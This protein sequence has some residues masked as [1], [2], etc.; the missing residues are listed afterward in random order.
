MSAGSLGRSG[1]TITNSYATGSVSGVSSVGG[2]VGYQRSGGT[3]TNSYAT[4]SVTGTG[5]NVGG[6]VG[7]S[8]GT[9][10]NSYVHSTYTGTRLVGNLATDPTGVSKVDLTGLT[11]LST[12]W[13]GKDWAFATNKFPDLTIIHKRCE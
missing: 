3:I 4:G 12:G 2:L 8:G 10:T 1:G 7:R 6:L 11:S 13:S 9:I 5:N